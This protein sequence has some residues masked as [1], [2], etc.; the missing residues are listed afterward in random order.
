MSLSWRK[1]QALQS[2]QQSW[3]GLGVDS[4]LWTSI[5]RNAAN[6][7]TAVGGSG[8]STTGIVTGITFKHGVTGVNGALTLPFAL[9]PTWVSDASNASVPAPTGANATGETNY[10]DNMT[11]RGSGLV[12]TAAYMPNQINSNVPGE[13]ISGMR[14]AIISGGSGYSVGEKFSLAS[15]TGQAA[16]D[17]AFGQITS[18]TKT[19]PE[20]GLN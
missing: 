17:S 11:C 12:F 9:P 16:A 6:V 2:D 3:R 14:F 7:K 15:I 19:A 5:D 1:R 10:D 8:A 13:D 4:A 18:V 20:P